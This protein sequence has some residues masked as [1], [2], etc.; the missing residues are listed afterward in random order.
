MNRH[1][2]QKELRG[3]LDDTVSEPDIQTVEHL[4]DCPRC[5]RSLEKLAAGDWWWTESR[6]LVAN[7]DTD[8]M[9]FASP[10]SGIIAVGDDQEHSTPNWSVDFLDPPTQPDLMGKLGKYHIESVIGYGG[11][12]IVLRGFDADLNRTVAI[13]VMAPHLAGSST[14]RKRFAREAQAAAAVVHDHVIAIHAIE[15]TGELPYL[16]MPYVSGTSLQTHVEQHGPLD[17][18]TIVRIAMQIASGLAAAHE[19]GLVHRDIKPANILLENGI[20]RVLITDFGLARAADDAS[21]TRSG[22]VA[23]TPHYMSPEQANGHPVDQRSDLFSLGSLVCFMATGRAPFRGDGAMA[24]LHSIC[25]QPV[26]P[27]R[28]VDPELPRPL[29]KLSSRLLCKSPS[30]R[31]SSAE[32]LREVLADYLAHLQNP[33]QQR[34]PRELSGDLRPV[35]AIAFTALVVSV[36]IGGAMWDWGANVDGPPSR[37]S[38]SSYARANA[39]VNSANSLPDGS[40]SSMDQLAADMDKIDRQWK[41]EVLTDVSRDPWDDMYDST[42]QAFRTVEQTW[43]EEYRQSADNQ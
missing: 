29:E 4:A 19:Q 22:L 36:S 13:K 5:Q 16:V 34:L 39:Q 30:D 3:L 41:R 28:E 9:R 31:F 26:K 32:R 25:N 2:E 17:A 6:E 18:K 11:M 38:G 42:N 21:I 7:S 37:R 10:A 12:G 27:L 40:L 35:I 15:T 23:G 24:V 14:A 1:C 33:I 20:S 8:E 43:A